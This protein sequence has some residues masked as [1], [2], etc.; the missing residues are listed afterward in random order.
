M[1]VQMLDSKKLN[2]KGASVIELIVV[3]AIIAVL[4]SGMIAGFAILNSSN[5]KEATRTTKTYLEKTRTSTMSVVADEWYFELSNTD[6]VSSAK[7]YKTITTEDGETTTSVI[8]SKEL[9]EKAVI[10]L[11]SDDTT[12]EIGDGDVLK[13]NFNKASGGVSSVELNSVKYTPGD[14]MISLYFAIGAK[15]SWVDLYFVSGNIEVR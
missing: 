7:V 12:I 4:L 9:S 10:S 13:I 14:N 8:E 5:L 1:T 6:G 11:I 3:I 2:N 15:E